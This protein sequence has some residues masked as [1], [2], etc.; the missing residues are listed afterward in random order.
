MISHCSSRA[1]S[2]GDAAP[3]RQGSGPCPALRIVV[4][5]AV[6]AVSLMLVIARVAHVQLGLARRYLDRL[7][8]SELRVEQIAAARGRILAAD[9]TVL[10]EDVPVLTLKVQYRYLE[11][12]LD[13]A[14]LSRQARLHLDAREQ[15]DRALVKRE[16]RRL[17]EQLDRMWDD[18]AA[19]FPCDAQQLLEA[20]ADVQRRVETIRGRVRSRRAAEVGAD[21]ELDARDPHGNRTW[22]QSAWDQVRDALTAEGEPAELDAL[23]LSEETAY[24]PVFRWSPEDEQMPAVLQVVAEIEGDPERYP[25]VRLSWQHRRRYPRGELACHWV[26]FVGPVTAEELQRSEGGA[27]LQPSGAGEAEGDLEARADYLAED[28]AGRLGVE[29]S[30]EATLRG[31]RGEVRE[32]VDRLGRS[33][34]E[35]ERREPMPGDDVVLWMDPALEQNAEAM[36]D[37]AVA[38]SHAA[39]GA[40]VVMDVHTGGVIAAAST[41]RFDPNELIRPDPQTWERLQRDPRRPLFDR[42]TRMAI[43]PGSVFKTATAIAALESGAIDPEEAYECRGYLYPDQPDRY[44]CLI[45]ARYGYGHGEMTLVDALMK[46]C[47]VYFFHTALEMGP[48]RMCRWYE[49]L[50]FGA[51][52]GIDLPYESGGYLPTPENVKQEFGHAW[53]RG[54]TP[55]LAIGQSYL[56]TTPLQIAR[57]MAAVANG[58]RLVRPRVVRRIVPRTGEP[59]APKGAAAPA[60]EGVDLKL[61]ARTLREVQEGLRRVV[62]EEGGTAHRT[63]YLSE[64]PI[65]GKTGTAEVRGREDHAWFAGYVPSDR[66]RYAFAVVLEHG[67]SGGHDA[68]PVGR[69]LIQAMME[70]GYFG[71]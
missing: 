28:F 4:L 27:G 7:D 65:S 50:G 1:F 11:R 55:R 56:Q 60:A 29:G 36:L 38:E 3:S 23:V 51:P 20:A 66:P 62:A 34:V 9:N 43:A 39:S 41:P 69:E 32:V 59:I 57:L 37:R 35:V 8:H 6:V 52:T 45:Y 5:R 12:P 46:S 33:M 19:L 14:W 13:E 15:R 26:G 47:N 58:G 42:V 30:Y 24:H 18:L 71:P 40:I 2:R 10:A 54:D 25:G 48:E 16:K 67:G 31:R 49:R 22:W 17:A 70:L 64:M 63:V 68:G 21:A 53:H 44:R 61:S